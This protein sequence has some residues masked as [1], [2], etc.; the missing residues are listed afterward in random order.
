MTSSCAIPHSAAGRE[1]DALTR[2]RRYLQHI[3]P[4][5]AGSGGD[6]ATYRAAAM[7]KGFSLTPEA[8]FPL[9]QEWNAACVP[10]WSE[11]KLRI[12]AAETQC[13][14]PALGLDMMGS[15]QAGSTALRAFALSIPARTLTDFV[16]FFTPY[17]CDTGNEIA[18]GETG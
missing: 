4:A 8:A 3:P 18:A 12:P 2:A 15:R 5:I 6:I 10:P 16:S 1:T 7:V 11:R 17:G 13:L 14:R 9:L